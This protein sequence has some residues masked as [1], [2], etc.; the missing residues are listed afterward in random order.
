MRALAVVVAGVVLAGAGPLGAHH[1]FSAEY[2][3]N[4]PIR[5]RGTV[6]KVEWT[7]PH[8]WFY[9]DVKTPAGKVQVWAIEAGTPNDL[10]RRG[11]S[12]RSLA[13]GTEIVIS[14]YRAK[15]GSLR[16]RGQDLALPD[17]RTLSLGSS[18]PGAP[19][20]LTPKNQKPR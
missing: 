5:V 6:T 13:V 7:N 16:A 8:A 15:D 3:A 1:S 20:E 4:K 17:G 14:G 2:D 11:F 9:V 19:T 18:G 10:F 12:K